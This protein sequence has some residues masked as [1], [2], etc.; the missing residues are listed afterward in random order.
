MWSTSNSRKRLPTYL[1][2]ISEERARIA[3]ELHDGIAQE[4]AAIG[5][6]L[7][8]EIG[9]TDTSAESRRALRTI[10]EEVTHLNA[11]VRAEIFQ[12]RTSRE[13]HAQDQLEQALQEIDI[14]FAIVG[15]LPKDAT[16]VELCKVLVELARNARD[17][18]EATTLE[19]DITTECITLENNGRTSHPIKDDRYGLVGI[20]ERL[21]SIGWEMTLESGFSQIEIRP[22]N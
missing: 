3:R 10:R 19:I 22:V 4:L 15:S 13:P 9:R 16:G 1:A 6:A 5:Y 7:D 17:H 20:A 12:L 14:D 2:D 8:S 21:H 11:K 18:G